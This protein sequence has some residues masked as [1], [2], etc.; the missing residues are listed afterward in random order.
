VARVF[1]SGGLGVL[2]KC[3]CGRVPFLKGMVC[4][5]LRW[6]LVVGSRRRVGC[7]WVLGPAGVLFARALVL[8]SRFH[9]SRGWSLFS[10]G[11][12]AL[13]GSRFVLNVCLGPVVG[14]VG[15]GGQVQFQNTGGG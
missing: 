7:P 4:C 2:P 9:N 15:V 13:V 3:R 1:F 5:A 8:G 14:W 6:A 11:C 10:R 12:A